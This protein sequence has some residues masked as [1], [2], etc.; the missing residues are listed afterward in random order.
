[1]GGSLREHVG[2]LADQPTR[3]NQQA[4]FRALLSAQVAVPLVASTELWRRLQRESVQEFPLG[5]RGTAPRTT[6]G[7]QR[8]A[9]SG[10]D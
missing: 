1:M 9:R 8:T 6:R 5:A 3:Q 10:G 4:F 2:R 7:R